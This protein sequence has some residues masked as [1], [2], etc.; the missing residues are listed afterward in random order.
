MQAEASLS[1]IDLLSYSSAGL[2]REVL[3]IK[4]GNRD[5]LVILCHN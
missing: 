3:Q 5:N 2:L 1:H 4:R